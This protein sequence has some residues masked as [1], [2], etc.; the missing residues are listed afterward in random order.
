MNQNINSSEESIPVLN[1]PN[2]STSKT[3]TKVYRVKEKNIG[4]V[5]KGKLKKKLNDEQALLRQKLQ[6]GIEMGNKE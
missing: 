5:S 4:L 6:K 1:K 3:E 2:S